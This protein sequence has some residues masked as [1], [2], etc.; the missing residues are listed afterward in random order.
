MDHRPERRLK[1]PVLRR[2]R[3]KQSSAEDE[4]AVRAYLASIPPAARSALERLRAI[5][6]AAVPGIDSRI[7][8]GI[9]AFTID[10]HPVIWYAAWTNHCSV[11]PIP[12]AMRTDPALEAFRISKGTIRFTPEKP[13]PVSLVKKLVKA[14]VAQH[15]TRQKRAKKQ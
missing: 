15:A 11:Y 2:A 9:P 13:L 12:A 3:K 10:G 1:T 14:Q 6:R 7:S 5:V 8:Y 4:A